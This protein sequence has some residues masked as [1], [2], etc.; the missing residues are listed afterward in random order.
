M[1]NVVLITGAAGWLGRLV[2]LSPSRINSHIHMES[3]AH[4]GLKG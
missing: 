2:C 1:S 4:T 3:L